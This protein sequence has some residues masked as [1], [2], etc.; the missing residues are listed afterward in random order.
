M[1]DCS[2]SG[3]A[4]DRVV[5]A[6]VASALNQGADGA[7]SSA[8]AAAAS[9][10]TR[11]A[12]AFFGGTAAT[13]TGPTALATAGPGAQMVM[14]LAPPEIV[15][16]GGAAAHRQVAMGGQ[17]AARLD[18]A[19]ADSAAA[20]QHPVH[21]APMNGRLVHP[22]HRHIQQM[23]MQHANPPQ[24]MM[25]QQQMMM[26]QQ[27]QMQQHQMAAMVQ[28][29]QQQQQQQKQMQQ[30]QQQQQQ[31][32]NAQKPEEVMHVH[33]SPPSEGFASG[34]SRA[35]ETLDDDLATVSEEEQ[36]HHEGL[37]EDASIERLAQAWREAEAEFA[38]EFG[39]D[40]YDA[41]DLGGIY[42]QDYQGA[43]TGATANAAAATSDQSAESQ[44]EFSEAS[45]TYGCLQT[46]TTDVPPQE[47]TYP[48]NLYE[49]GLRHFEEG[50]ISEAILC[51][52]SAL[53]NVDPDHAD[54]WRMLG[55]CHTENDEDRRAI[56]C[57]HRSLERDPFSPETLLALG[58]AYVNEL[59]HD[60]AVESLRGWVA[61]HPLYAGMDQGRGEEGVED[62]YGS[63]DADEE[64][65]GMRGRMNPRTAAEMRDVERLLLRALDYDRTADAA[66]DVYEALGV[67]YN[68]SRDYDAAADAFRRAIDV[69]PD[70]YQLRNKLGATL[71]NGNRSGE[72]LPSYRAA[73]GLKPKYA[74]GWLNLAISHSNLHNYG[75][76][77]RCYLQTLSLN[78]DARHVWGYLRIAL[79]CDERWD[80][81]PLAASQDLGAFHDH[82]DF[83]EH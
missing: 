12:G 17:G 70:D 19:W 43:V 53:R 75:E 33:Q 39:D 20:A 49:R 34:T 59:D 50:N 30:Q 35:E 52:E 66:A 80:L 51:F 63:G 13:A 40:E 15:G 65:S 68:V 41:S 1:A 27:M 78:P 25:H 31:Q 26:M 60:R 36:L 61:N 55:R 82:F 2:A 3:T 79:T 58:V 7:S 57:W 28:Y 42:N 16:G 8:S 32:M 14:P 54:A 44:Y 22:Q 10:A 18:A 6:A 29:Q 77:A 5:H 23:P 76:A 38:E 46:E 45:R 48:E 62:L 73:L 47:L 72:A 37:T 4:I 21:S 74:R 69:R 81:L 24:M 9:A 71:A 64:D 11:A 56:A 67:V 83:V